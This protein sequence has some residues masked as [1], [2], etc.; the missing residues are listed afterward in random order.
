M[1]VVVVVFV[2]GVVVIVAVV[3]AVVV[4]VPLGQNS[5]EVKSLRTALPRL[6]AFLMIR[7]WHLSTTKKKTFSEMAP[8]EAPSQ[9]LPVFEKTYG[10]AQDLS[11]NH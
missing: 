10:F 2:A 7:T 5:F 11:K 6:R 4:V 1:V 3:A 9:A 8:S